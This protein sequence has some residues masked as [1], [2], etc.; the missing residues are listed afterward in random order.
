MCRT[1]CTA[2]YWTICPKLCIKKLRCDRRHAPPIFFCLGKRKRAVHGPK[3]NRLPGQDTP[4]E[5]SGPSVGRAWAVHPESLCPRR[6]ERWATWWSTKGLCFDSRAFRFATR[7][8]A[9]S[10]QR[11]RKEKRGH[12]ATAPVN[13]GGAACGARFMARNSFGALGRRLPDFLGSV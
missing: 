6:M 8:R 2:L 4:A 9:R 10:R 11:Q 12:A 5:T 3:E 7:C 13:M 1:Y